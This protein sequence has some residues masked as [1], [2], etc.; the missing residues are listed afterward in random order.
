MSLV[1]TVPECARS[2]ESQQAF[3]AVLKISTRRVARQDEG[4]QEKNEK[5]SGAQI[6]NSG[7]VKG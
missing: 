3:K 7:K 5:R 1:I 2:A 6:L 4:K